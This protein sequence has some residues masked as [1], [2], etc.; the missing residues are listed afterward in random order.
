MINP[1]SFF[2]FKI[3]VL[4]TTLFTF[5]I[6]LCSWYNYAW[7]QYGRT[8]MSMVEHSV[9]G[10]NICTGANYCKANLFRHLLTMSTQRSCCN[11]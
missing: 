6:T 8:I 11:C 10:A 4:N 7:L 9:T 5:Y 2:K 1:Y 3:F